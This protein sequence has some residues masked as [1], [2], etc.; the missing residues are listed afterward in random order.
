VFGWKV[1]GRLRN[2]PRPPEI[3]NWKHSMKII[4][5]LKIILISFVLTVSAL[6][7]EDTVLKVA[8][9]ADQVMGVVDLGVLQVQGVGSVKLTARREGKQLVVQA[10]GPDEKVIGRAETVIGVK[11]TQ[12]FVATPQGLKTL[13]VLWKEP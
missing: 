3:R 8:Q 6:A 5:F 10:L 11:E 2:S 4:D 9:K 1:G 12:V 13:T 7:S